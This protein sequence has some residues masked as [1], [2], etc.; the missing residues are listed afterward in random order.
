M[1]VAL[2]V[3]VGVCVAL[4]VGVGVCV[5]DGVALGVTVAVGVGVPG[6]GVGDGVNPAPVIVMRPLVWRGVCDFRFSSMKKKLPGFAR[7]ASGVL[8]PG[9]LLTLSIL[10]R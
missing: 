3:G 2:G 10:S 6:V 8:A 4:G 1:C 7:Q 5:A 9:V